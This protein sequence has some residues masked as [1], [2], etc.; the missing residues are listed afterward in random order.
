MAIKLYHIA[1][2]TLGENCNKNELLLLMLEF[3]IINLTTLLRLHN[4]EL[5]LT[6]EL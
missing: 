6:G 5:Y 3:N 1:T 2:G 4:A